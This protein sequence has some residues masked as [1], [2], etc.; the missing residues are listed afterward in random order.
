MV[1]K[2]PR[3]DPRRVSLVEI[4]T[5]RSPI[6]SATE[7][8]KKWLQKNIPNAN[9]KELFINEDTDEWKNFLRDHPTSKIP[10]QIR[11]IM[12]NTSRITIGGIEHLSSAFE[13]EDEDLEKV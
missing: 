13:I 6:C 11:V 4:F 12:Q 8:V 9:I 7:E 10:P 5:R 2:N 3:L 1:L